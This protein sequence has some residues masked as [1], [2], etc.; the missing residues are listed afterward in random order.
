[1]KEIFENSISWKEP[2][3]RYFSTDRFLNLLDSSNLYFSAAT[4]FEDPFEGSVAVVSPSYKPDP[5]YAEMERYE[6]AFYELKRLTKISCWHRANYESD[7]MWKL[8]AL[9][10]KGVAITT[11]PE[12]LKKALSPYK[13]KPEFADEQLYGG[14][15]NYIDLA[16]VRL[17]TSML[18]TFYHKHKAFEWEKEFR[19]SISLRM[20]EEF[21]VNVPEKGIEV[22]TNL[23]ELISKIVL[24]PELTEEDKAKIIYKAE[25]VGVESRIEISTLLYT[26]KYI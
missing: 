24:G 15:I 10:R 18:E 6:Q 20:A 1:M 25:E 23:K 11:T 5:R 19:L 16:A 22:Q 26:P 21:G 12:K 8:Y 17:K 2:L 3:W 13:I 4:Q 7:A 9:K 14:A